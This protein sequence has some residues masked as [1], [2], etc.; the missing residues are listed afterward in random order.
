MTWGMAAKQNWL[1]SLYISKII[2][3]MADVL[4]W[5]RARAVHLEDAR[6]LPNCAAGY[7]SDNTRL[8]MY[9]HIKAGDANAQAE[10]PPTAF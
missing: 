8:K 2:V 3:N 5:A 7:P 10:Y 9:L 1:N 6:R 4:Q